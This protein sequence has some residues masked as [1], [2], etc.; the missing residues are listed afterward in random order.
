MHRGNLTVPASLDSLGQ[1][2]A[3]VLA[4]ADVAGVQGP[5][6]YRLR[7]AV[8]EIATNVIVHGCRAGAP[9]CVPESIDVV[10]ETDDHTL[11]VILEDKGRPFDPRELPPPADLHASPE[12]R[13]I[14]GLG[15][16]LALGGVDQFVY[17]RIG[18]KNRNVFVVKRPPAA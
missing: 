18:D 13:Q 16:F 8:D 5:A 4:A 15:V 12:E 17:E 9:G 2:A 1:I 11:K 14:G 7:L 10:T 3:F 6:R